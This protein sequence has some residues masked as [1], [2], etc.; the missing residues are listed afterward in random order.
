MKAYQ[1]LLRVLLRLVI[2]LMLIAIS[3]FLIKYIFGEWGFR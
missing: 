1:A 2:V 3:L